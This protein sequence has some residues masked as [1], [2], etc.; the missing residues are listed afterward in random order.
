[1]VAGGLFGIYFGGKKT[2]LA[3]GRMLEAQ[4]KGE[5]EDLILFTWFTGG[6]G[7]LLLRWGL[8]GEE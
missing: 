2:A 3:M 1:M 5:N 8:P 7:V 6:M 4:E